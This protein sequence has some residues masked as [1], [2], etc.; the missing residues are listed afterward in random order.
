MDRAIPKGGGATAA[1]APGAVTGELSIS[2]QFFH[3]N[4]TN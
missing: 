3:Y 2:I 4:A 1:V